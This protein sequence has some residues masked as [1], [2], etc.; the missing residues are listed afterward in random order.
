MS[1]KGQKQYALMSFM[2]LLDYFAHKSCKKRHHLR[3]I[4]LA[5]FLVIDCLEM[6]SAKFV[7]ILLLSL[8]KANSI[9]YILLN[10]L[11]T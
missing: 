1:H 4:F 5:K 8:G 7:Y 11:G 9:V 10:S 3:L 2:I 6:T